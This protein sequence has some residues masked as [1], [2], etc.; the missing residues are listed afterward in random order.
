MAEDPFE[1][2]EVI[3]RNST[4]VIVVISLMAFVLLYSGAL[5]ALAGAAGVGDGVIM[6]LFAIAVNVAAV[7]YQV[8]AGKDINRKCNRPYI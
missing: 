7:L 4:I 3:E 6:F 1:Q 2:A 5:A 8:K